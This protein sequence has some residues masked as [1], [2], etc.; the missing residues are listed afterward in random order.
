MTNGRSIF[1]SL[2]IVVCAAFLVVVT[3]NINRTAAQ[4]KPG[5]D[6]SATSGSNPQ[7]ARGKYIVENVAFCINCHTPRDANGNIDRSRLLQ[8]TPLF[9]RPAQTVADW[10]IVAPRI[11]GTPP[12]TDADMV[13]LLTT[14]IWYQ[15]GKPLRDPMPRFHMTKDDAEAVVAFLKTVK[16]GQ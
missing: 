7:I 16:T 5:K 8:G 13:T 14:G 1:K 4:T 2:M 11:G 12:G 3:A 10:P 9:F 15:T 6:A